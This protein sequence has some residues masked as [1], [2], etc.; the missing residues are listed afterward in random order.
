[1]SIIIALY[2]RIAQA[3]AVERPRLQ[4]LLNNL[5][6]LEGGNAPGG[7]M[8]SY[9]INA[10][11][12]ATDVV[13]G[14]LDGSPLCALRDQYLSLPEVQ[15]RLIPL[16]RVDALMIQPLARLIAGQLGDRLRC[17]ARVQRV[18][19]TNGIYA[20][21]DAQGVLLARSR[22][23]V[24]CTGGQER[25]LPE[26][27]PW[28]D[29]THFAADFL[30]LTSLDKLASLRGDVVIV[31]ASHS[32][33]SCAWRLLYDPLFEQFSQSR[34]IRM[35]QRRGLVKLRCTP[36]F[37]QQQGLVYDAERDI[38]PATGLVYRHAGMRKDA[39][40][41][42]LNI[43]DGVEQ[44]AQLVPIKRL[45]DRAAELDAAGLI[46]QASGFH[47]AMPEL[48]LDGS[49][50]DIAPRSTQGELRNAETGAVIPG[51]YANGLGIQIIPQGEF[52]GE[53]SFKG[54]VDGLQSYPL[55]VAPQIIDQLLDV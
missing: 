27:E 37:A 10:N 6:M 48:E 40:T 35:L 43:R 38:C 2:N 54:S 20:S 1:M 26:L 49:L 14:I 46:L 19:G 25:L 9:Q 42:Y 52:R 16:P 33:F 45:S 50:V 53:P 15:Q 7:A 34:A 11:T 30:R 12:N 28:R 5:V 31:G 24:L 13:S 55:A 39:K 3:G 41:L 47:A 8:G 22:S 36:E 29:K 23:L 21:Y 44:R 51:L 17:Q 32:A 4:A 18:V